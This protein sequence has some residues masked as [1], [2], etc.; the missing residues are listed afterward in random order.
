MARILIVDDSP[1]Q[2]TGISRIVEKLGHVSLTAEDGAAG[3]EAAKRERIDDVTAD[4]SL[5]V[6]EGRNRFDPAGERP[7]GPFPNQGHP[8]L[9]LGQRKLERL[10][11]GDPIAAI[12]PRFEFAQAELPAVDGTCGFRSDLPGEEGRG[13]RK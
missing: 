11:G 12:E 9:E 4:A 13:G 6:A 10:H 2:V 8:I 5:V 3:V 7:L 1:S